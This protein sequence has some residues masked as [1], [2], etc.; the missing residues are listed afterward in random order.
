MLIREFEVGPE[1]VR[2]FADLVQD[3]NPVHLDPE[4]AATTRYKQPICH[5]MLCA[6]FISGCLVEAFGQGTI[7]LDQ[8]LQFLRTVPVGSRLRVVLGDPTPEGDRLR[9]PTRLELQVRNLWKKAIDGS[10]LILPGQVSN[11]QGSDP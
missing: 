3:H 2:A 9:V 1:Q 6:S 10:A 8:Q 4:F 11:D 5:G 7:Y